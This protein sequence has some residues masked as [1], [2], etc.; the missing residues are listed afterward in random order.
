MVEGVNSTMTYARTFVNV[1]MYPQNN[2]N[3][4]IRQKIEYRLWMT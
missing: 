2:N 3:K 1:A 4:N